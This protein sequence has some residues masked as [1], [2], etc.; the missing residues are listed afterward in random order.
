MSLHIFLPAVKD[1][2]TFKQ[3]LD[4]TAFVLKEVLNV[5]LLEVTVQ[6]SS[7]LVLSVLVL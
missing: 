4:V 3:Q 6:V 1:Q 7:I 5:S 2:L